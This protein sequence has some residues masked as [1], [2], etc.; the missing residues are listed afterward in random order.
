[1]KSWI[2]G[3]ILCLCL[4]LVTSV[5]ANEGFYVTGSLG[6]S[7]FS[8]T[9]PDGTWRQELLGYQ[10]TRQSLMLSAGLGYTWSAWSLE[11]SYLDLG[12]VTVQGPWVDDAQ[13]G[14]HRF[15]GS[16]AP[17]MHVVHGRVTDHVYGGAI[18]IKRSMDLGLIH[19]FLSAGIW[20]GPHHAQVWIQNAQ[21]L[22][23]VNF[24]GIVGGVVA[25]GGLCYHWICGQVE[26]Y[27]ALTQKGFPVSTEI[28]VP[29]VRVTI[30]LDLR[31]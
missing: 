21:D 23:T 20:G 27:K 15:G 14:A 30:P 26:Y 31:W 2:C 5:Q 10:A 24:T 3:V 25:G 18:K 28:I 12:H 13:Y 9:T 1:M 8:L 19:P 29:S 11:A 16:Q 17:W 6:Q 4:C 22:Q 7:R